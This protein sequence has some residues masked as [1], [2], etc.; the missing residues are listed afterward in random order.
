MPQT[1]DMGPTA[2]LLL[3]RKVIENKMCH[4]IFSATLSETFVIPRR[5]ARDTIKVH[6]GLHV[7]YSL[8]LSDF[9]ESWI[10]STD[11]LNILKYQ[12]F[13]KISPERVE[14]SHAE[15]RTDGQ[16][17]R[18]NEANSRFSQFFERAQTKE[19]GSK[20]DGDHSTYVVFFLAG[21]FYCELLRLKMLLL[22]DRESLSSS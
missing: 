10:F 12:I 5:T 1:Y 14:L 21:C 3:R 18:H 8:F 2:L 22:D 17:D 11:F 19:E 16:I 7:N 15:G 13:M 4:M 20:T 6:F 9:N